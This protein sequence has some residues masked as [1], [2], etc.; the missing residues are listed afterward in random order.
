MK[1][2]VT[3]V[4]N[5]PSIILASKIVIS[6]GLRPKRIVL[7]EEQ[8][9]F[10]VTFE[11]MDASVEELTSNERGSSSVTHALVFEHSCFDQGSYFNFTAVSGIT[12]EDA[13]YAA[14]A[15]YFERSTAL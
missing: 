1:T 3:H 2:N 14:K 7:R 9:K 10:V 15:R 13:F 12:R 4:R 6:E 11:Y 5:E 8:T